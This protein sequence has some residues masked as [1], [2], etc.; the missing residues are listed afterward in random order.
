M[1]QKTIVSGFILLLF[2]MIPTVYAINVTID[3]DYRCDGSN[4]RRVLN[5]TAGNQTIYI[6]E[7]LNCEFGCDPTYNQCIIA[8]Y[9]EV[10]ILFVVVFGGLMFT[11]WIWVKKSRR[12]RR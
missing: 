6:D 5:G 4:L 3:W 1:I 8:P 11:R 10:I 7:G 12:R 9:Y 2:L